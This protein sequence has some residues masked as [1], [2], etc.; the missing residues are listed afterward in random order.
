MRNFIGVSYPIRLTGKALTWH[1][2]TVQI[3]P[4]ERLLMVLP[5]PKPPN[6]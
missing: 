4:S 2:V 3:V 1:A 6:P 5:V